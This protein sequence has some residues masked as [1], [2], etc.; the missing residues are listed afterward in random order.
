MWEAK[1]HTR[2]RQQSYN[3]VC[4]NVYFGCLDG[5]V[6]IATCYGLDGPGLNS[7]EGEIISARPDRPLGPPRAQ[8]IPGLF[9]GGKERVDVYLYS[10]CPFTACY[11]V[12]F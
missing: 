7:G 11:T 6:C 10:P 5:A 4:F 1:F 2:I 9:P 8:W 12:I 3:F